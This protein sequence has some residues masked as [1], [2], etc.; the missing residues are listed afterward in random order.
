VC[1]GSILPVSPEAA[2][3][4]RQ[5]GIDQRGFTAVG[6]TQFL[7]QTDQRVGFEA[8]PRVQNICSIEILMIG[9]PERRRKLSIPS[10]ARI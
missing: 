5:N 3:D 8:P 1:D 2:F 7:H 9:G 10:F 6:R 4:Q